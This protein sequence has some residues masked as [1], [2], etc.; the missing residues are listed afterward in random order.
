[1]GEK[2]VKTPVVAKP[3]AGA[4]KSKKLIYLAVAVIVVA[5]VIWILVK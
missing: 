4:P 3:V 5:I 1:M 2:I